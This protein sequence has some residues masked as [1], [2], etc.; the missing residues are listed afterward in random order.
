M[1]ISRREY[2]SSS[3]IS[4]RLKPEIIVLVKASNN[5]TNRSTDRPTFISVV[6]SSLRKDVLGPD[7]KVVGKAVQSGIGG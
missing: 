3:C 5:L 2:T 1:Y 6:V 7:Q 4:R